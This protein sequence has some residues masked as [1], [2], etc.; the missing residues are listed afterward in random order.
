MKKIKYN[1]V[2]LLALGLVFTTF[3]GCTKMLDKKPLQATLDDLNQGGLEG[4]VYG[5][6]G[7]LRNPD[8]G[9]A[10]WGHI[11]WLAIHS[12]RD[13]DAIKGSSESDGADWAVIYDQFQYSKDHWSTNIYYERKYQM[14]IVSI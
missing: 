13:D 10:A 7:G 8:L 2:Y 9:G 4:M 11:P 12:F 6:Y 3:L 1:I 5:L 14:I